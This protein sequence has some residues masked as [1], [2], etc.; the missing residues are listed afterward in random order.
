[1]FARLHRLIEL[2]LNGSSDGDFV[3]EMS[4]FFDF[5]NAEI[6][7]RGWVPYRTE[8]SIF[9]E[10]HWPANNNQKHN[11]MSSLSVV[12]VFVSMVCAEQQHGSV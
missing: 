12:A 10:D 11:A 7:P 6:I 3:Q 8:W 9:D 1:M 5:L 2:F 4:T